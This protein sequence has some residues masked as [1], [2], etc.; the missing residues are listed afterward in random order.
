MRKIIFQMLISLDGNF[1]GPGHDISWH[2][3]DAEFNDYAIDLLRKIDTILFGRVTY[4]MMA[5][6][7]P[8]SLALRDDPVVAGL[9]NSMHKVV[10]SSTLQQATWENTRLVKTNAIEE[11][12]R[13]KKHPG[14]DMA[15]F[16]SSDL[17]ASLLPTAQID[18]FHIIINPL[19][20]GRGKP[21]FCGVKERIQLELIKTRTFRNGNVLLVYKPVERE[22]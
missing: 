5:A 7:W 8:T 16:G 6:Y 19:V 1:E 2:N 14:K 20:L 21:L 12:R 11:I 15:I 13:L 3:V 17:A 9:M 18:E 4:D 22:K 10:F